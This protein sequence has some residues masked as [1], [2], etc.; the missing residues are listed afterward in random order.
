V[1]AALKRLENLGFDLVIIS[2]QPAA[3]KG[4]TSRANLD[5]THA[6][7]V[8]RAEAE[9]AHIR[10]SYI[11]FHKAED[12]CACRKPGIGL[13][14]QAF[15]DKPQAPRTQSWMAG[16]GVTDVQ[17]GQRFGLKTAFLAA[18]KCDVCQTVQ[19]QATAPTL[20]ATDLRDLVKKLE[21]K[22]P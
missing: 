6:E 15:R 18:H 8:Q 7:I 3:A 19:D 11:C 22:I 10:G 21:G 16:D 9:G 14:E 12:Q 17:A 2:N 5:K 13:L 4:K 20:W 1:P